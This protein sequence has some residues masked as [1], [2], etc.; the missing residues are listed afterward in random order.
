MSVIILILSLYSGNGGVHIKEVELQASGVKSGMVA[1]E[2]LGDK[3]VKE[4]D[5]FSVTAHYVCTP[6][7][8]D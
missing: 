6:L 3:F 7:I 1:C 8:I 4:N 5:S 2:K